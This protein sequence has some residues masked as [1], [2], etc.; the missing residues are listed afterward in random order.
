MNTYPGH[1]TIDLLQRNRSNLLFSNRNKVSTLFEQGKGA[2]D[3]LPSS[4][5]KLV[6]TRSLSQ[7]V[8]A[9]PKLVEMGVWLLSHL[10]Q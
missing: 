3:L 8:L 9:Q 7:I 10:L 5:Y 2:A 4:S 6:T 1:G